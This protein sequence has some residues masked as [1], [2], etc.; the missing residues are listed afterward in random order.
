MTLNECRE[1]LKE[2]YP[3]NVFLIQPSKSL[4]YKN[5]KATYTVYELLPNRRKFVTHVEDRNTMNPGEVFKQ[6]LTIL[7]HHFD[8]CNFG[9][10]VPLTV[11]GVDI[12]VTYQYFPSVGINL[13]DII[14]D[15]EH[16][17]KILHDGI[18]SY[19]AQQAIKSEICLYEYELSKRKQLDKNLSE[20]LR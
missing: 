4:F 2:L 11:L 18:V 10:E 17:D 1:K 14:Y 5:F 6:I 8:Y 13:L 15:S 9:Y 20:L 12:K 19:M 7:R 3:D 16:D